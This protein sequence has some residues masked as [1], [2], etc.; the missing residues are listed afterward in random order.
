MS[1]LKFLEE[2]DDSPTK[3]GLGMYSGE[4]EYVAFFEQCS[5]TGQVWYF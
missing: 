1:K 2:E 5:C 3:Q 4:N